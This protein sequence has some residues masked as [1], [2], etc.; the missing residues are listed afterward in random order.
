MVDALN[1]L[2]FNVPYTQDGPFS[3]NDA[4]AMIAGDGCVIARASIRG[5]CAVPTGR[6]I[7]TYGSAPGVTGHAV[8]VLVFLG[9]FIVFDGDVRACHTGHVSWHIMPEG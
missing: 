6:Y 8:A 5:A 3:I 2:G 7:A 1:A 9:G 4:E